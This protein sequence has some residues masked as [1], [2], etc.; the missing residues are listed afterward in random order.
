MPTNLLGLV[1]QLLHASRP[2]P[3][4]VAAVAETRP[5][6]R[7]AIGAIGFGLALVFVTWLPLGIYDI[8]PFALALHGESSLRMH[9]AVAVAC[10]LLAAWGFWD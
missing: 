9:G 6:R 8:V 5:A 3:C 1:T 10:L 7:R 4:G 2:N